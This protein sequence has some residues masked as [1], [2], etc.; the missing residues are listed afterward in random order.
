MS[1]AISDWPIV[2]VVK[3]ETKNKA[4]MTARPNGHMLAKRLFLERTENLL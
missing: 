3:R 2:G 4:N 1:P